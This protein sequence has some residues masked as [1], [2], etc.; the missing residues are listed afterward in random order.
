MS[1]SAVAE[2]EDMKKLSLS[3]NL[4]E[5]TFSFAPCAHQATRLG[6]IA[7]DLSQDHRLRVV[8]DSETAKEACSSCLQRSK[9]IDIQKKA[10]PILISNTLF[11]RPGDVET[12]HK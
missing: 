5:R 3:P 10:S 2:D 4:P 9:H 11:G 7:D 6:L 8:Q 12:M 1:M